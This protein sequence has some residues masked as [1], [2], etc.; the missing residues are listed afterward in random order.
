LLSCI[1]YRE[2]TRAG[3]AH[4]FFA[5]TYALLLLPL[6]VAFIIESESSVAK[7]LIAA[8]LAWQVIALSLFLFYKPSRKYFLYYQLSYITAFAMILL[9]VSYVPN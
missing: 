7:I 3:T 8:L 5:W 4:T 2:G 9:V 6:A 1:A